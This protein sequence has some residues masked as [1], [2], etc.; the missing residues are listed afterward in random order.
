MRVLLATDGS[1]GALAAT[2][3]LRELPLPAGT[4]IR[5]LAVVTIPPSPL[6]IPPVREY[7]DALRAAYRQEAEAARALLLSRALTDVRVV[8]GD[9]REMIIREACDW[10][11][12]LV[13]VGARGF[14]TIGR[15]LIG[16]VSSAVLH[17]A[18]GAVAIVRGEPRRPRRLVVACDG[19]PDAFNAVRF[20]ARF[21]LGRETGVRVLGVASPAN[22]PP[23][24]V[25]ALSIPW[26]LPAPEL[27]DAEKAALESALTG[28]AA[29]L[30]PSVGPIETS[31]VRG[32]PAAEI[33]AACDEPGVDL[34]VLGARGRG[35]FERM[36]LGSVSDRVAHHARCTVLVVRDKA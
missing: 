3:W 29:E 1:D 10:P 11:A 24:A 19:S 5:V 36:M 9:A 21:P 22:V 25:Q 13:V 12:D 35:L 27:L 16:S 6:D 18:P 8:D 15:F 32:H 23:S 34:V 26:P 17:G 30:A 28:A 14:G 7:N 2:R 31:V 4:A 20:V 33:L